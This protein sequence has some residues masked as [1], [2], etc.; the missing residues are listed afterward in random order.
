MITKIRQ[1]K[2]HRNFGTQWKNNGTRSIR[3]MGRD[4]AADS[5]IPI[6]P[7]SSSISS[8]SIE[9]TVQDSVPS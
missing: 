5:G 3:I 6:H 4:L 9:S 7:A 2:R 8:T 1:A